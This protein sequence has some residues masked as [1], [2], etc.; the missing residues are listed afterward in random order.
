MQNSV[1]FRLGPPIFDQVENW[2]RAQP[3]I[4]ARADAVREL[5]RRA[6]EAEH[7]HGL[8]DAAKAATK[9][10]AFTRSGQS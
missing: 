2:R 5:L 1:Q 3:K 7:Q 10:I 6:L 8:F 4:P 9:A